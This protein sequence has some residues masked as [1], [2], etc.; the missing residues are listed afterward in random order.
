MFLMSDYRIQ[1]GSQIN[2]S[3]RLGLPNPKGTLLSD[4]ERFGHLFQ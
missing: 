3:V 4:V 1:A 2:F